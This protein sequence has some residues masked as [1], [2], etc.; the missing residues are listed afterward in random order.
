M[1][2]RAGP[3]AACAPAGLS[4]AGLNA[5]L[6]TR[7]YATSIATPVG[8]QVPRYTCMSRLKSGC[9]VKMVKKNTMRMPTVPN[10]MM[11]VGKREC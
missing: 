5:F 8:A 4:A 2:A 6:H 10:K 7:K 11:A 9:A 1:C 3:Y